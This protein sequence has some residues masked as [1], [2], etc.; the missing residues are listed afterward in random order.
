VSDFTDEDRDL[1]IC[2]RSAFAADPDEEDNVPG[3]D[4]FWSHDDGSNY[5]APIA[6]AECSNRKGGCQFPQEGWDFTVEWEEDLPPNQELGHGFLSSSI[7]MHV[8]AVGSA[9]EAIAVA[10]KE[11]GDAYAHRIERGKR[12]ET[13]VLFMGS[14]V[15]EFPEVDPPN[16]ELI[17]CRCIP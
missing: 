6:C 2:A 10:R 11:K 1:S 13:F 15:G 5:F 16:L 12:D 8:A 3:V 17:P 9:A 4:W 7:C 14:L